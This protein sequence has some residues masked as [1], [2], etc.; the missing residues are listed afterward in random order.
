MPILTRGTRALV[1]P[2]ATPPSTVCTASTLT[3]SH[4]HFRTSSVSPPPATRRR[5]LIGGVLPTIT[6]IC[7]ENVTAAEEQEEAYERETR[8]AAQE[9]N[10]PQLH[11]KPTMT[12]RLLTVFTHV[13]V[14]Q[15]HPGIRYIMGSGGAAANE[16]LPNFYLDE[17]ALTSEKLLH[18]NSSVTVL[19]LTVSLEGASFMR[20]QFSNLMQQTMAM[21]KNMG[22]GDK[23]E[24][25]IKRLVTDTDP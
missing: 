16:Y 17:L 21:Q 7:P 14:G 6:C 8:L 9:R 2:S 5:R 15:L 18:L 4:S 22:A 24:D 12:L 23:D 1:I 25:E 10:E 3:H 20:W 13:P 11:W 19:P